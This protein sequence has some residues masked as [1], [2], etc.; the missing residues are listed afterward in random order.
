M[1]TPRTTVKR[2]QWYAALAAV[3]CTAGAWPLV[4]QTAPDFCGCRNH[5]AS[6]G[7]FDMALTST[8]PPGTTIANRVVQIPLPADGVLVFESFRAVRPDPFSWSIGFQRNDANTPVTM[9][10]KG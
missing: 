8:Y 2:R 6:L 7:H 5:P 3:L 10:V 9:L 1:I 4:G